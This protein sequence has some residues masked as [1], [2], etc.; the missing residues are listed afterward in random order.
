MYSYF[1][2]SN[3]ILRCFESLR[4]TK[5]LTMC[6]KMGSIG[7]PCFQPKTGSCIPQDCFTVRNGRI[8]SSQWW[9]FVTASDN[10]CQE[11]G[12]RCPLSFCYLSLFLQPRIAVTKVAILAQEATLEMESTLGQSTLRTLWS[13]AHLFNLNHLSLVI[14][15]R[16]K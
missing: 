6:G 14:Y 11:V 7:L 5:P 15:I 1:Y 8:T 2:Q 3:F 10:F 16:Q 9:N 12:S 13:T 4:L